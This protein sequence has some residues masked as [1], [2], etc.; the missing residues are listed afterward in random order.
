MSETIQPLLS[1]DDILSAYS[2]FLTRILGILHRSPKVKMGSSLS[3][4]Y[5]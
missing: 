5:L 2:A 4:L 1:G 3:L